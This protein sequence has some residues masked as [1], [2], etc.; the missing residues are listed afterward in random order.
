[1]RPA[2]RVRPGDPA[3]LARNQPQATTM[4]SPAE[5][6]CHRRVTIPTKFE[7]GRLIAGERKRGT[8]SGFA[9]AGVNDHIAVVFGSVG[10][11]EANTKLLREVGTPFLAV[12]EC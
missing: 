4:E 5:R 3:D 9:A 7:N 11:S 6:N 10:R 1:T 12:D 2:P 8:K